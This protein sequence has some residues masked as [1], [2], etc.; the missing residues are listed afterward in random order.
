MRRFIAVCL[1]AHSVAGAQSPTQLISPEGKITGS[2]GDINGAVITVIKPGNVDGKPF[3][4]KEWNK[5]SVLF[6]KGKKADSLLLQF[7]LVSNKLYFKQDGFTMAFLEEVEAFLFY[8]SGE[9]VPVDMLFRNGYPA[10]GELG[11]ETFYEVLADGAKI[12]L[13][14][15]WS[16]KITETYVYNQPPRRQYTESSGLYLYNTETASLQRV[17]TGKK[18]ILKVLPALSEKID[19]LCKKNKWDLNTEPEVTQLVKALNL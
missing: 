4:G 2:I 19:S 8:T 12:H 9:D 18:N 17:K 7:D 11:R 10:Y 5:G 13:L 6:K 16:A 15:H 3:L 14:K 1:L